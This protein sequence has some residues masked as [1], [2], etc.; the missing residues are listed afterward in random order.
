MSQR[1]APDDPR[2]SWPGA[3]SLETNDDGVRPW[4]MPYDKIGLIAP[5]LADR[6]GMPAGVRIA[7]RS[8]T[9]AIT[10]ALNEFPD[11]RPIDIVCDGI[12]IATMP[13]AGMDSFTFEGLPEGMKTIELWLSQM[14]KITLKSLD[15]DDGATLEAYEDTRPRWIVY[16]SSITHCSEA[17]TPTG[18]WPA[19]VSRL[20]G[21]NHTSLGLGAENHHDA[22]VAMAIRDMPADF[23]TLKLGINPQILHTLGMRT[24]RTTTK[25]FVRI[26][27]EKHLDVPITIVS[28]IWAAARETEPND[29]GIN[30]ETTRT[31]LELAVEELRACG[32]ENV[33]YVNGLDLFGKEHADAGHL[34]DN[35]HPNE[36]GYRIMGENFVEKVIP[37][38]FV[39]R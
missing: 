16:G 38:Y 36:D 4:R 33:Y 25:G 31:E 9:T 1:I 14:G 26:I 19:V 15:I 39:Q 7:F 2:L 10:C 29:I 28:S 13:T 35:L 21:F 30:I 22:M 18:T 24:Y 17:P 5:G 20:A 34:P 12:L 32:D 11:R 8:D 23:I 37:R 27:R 6:A 3:V